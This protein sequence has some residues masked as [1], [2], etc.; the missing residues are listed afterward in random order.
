MSVNAAW[1]L[2]FP[3]AHFAYHITHRD[4][5]SSYRLTPGGRSRRPYPAAPVGP[6]RRVGPGMI[7]LPTPRAVIDLYESLS[8]D[9]KAAF[10]RALSGRMTAKHFGLML[11]ALPR[12]ELAQFSRLLNESFIYVAAPKLAIEI[13]RVL[14]K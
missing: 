14:R 6:A 3:P 4:G 10:R 11:D 12:A 1:E 9:N 7:E 13:A 8:D 2:L 5:R